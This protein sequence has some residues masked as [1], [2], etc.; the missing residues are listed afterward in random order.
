MGNPY[1]HVGENCSYGYERAIDIVLSLLT[2][3]G[4]RDRSNMNDVPF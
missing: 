3:F 1:V 4:S 2:D